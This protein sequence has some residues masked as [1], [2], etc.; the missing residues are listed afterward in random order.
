MLTDLVIQSGYVRAQFHEKTGLWAVT[1]MRSSFD[2]ITN[3][4][5]GRM[6][7]CKWL[8][9]IVFLE[10]VAGVPGMVGGMVGPLFKKVPSCLECLTPVANSGK[11]GGI[12]G[13]SHFRTSRTPELIGRRVMKEAR[14]CGVLGALPVQHLCRDALMKC[15]LLVH[16]SSDCAPWRFSIC[17]FILPQ[18]ACHGSVK[19]WALWVLI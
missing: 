10:T 2:F 9:R 16:R 14:T 11:V 18:V 19:A 8:Q 13:P 7:E 15:R 1:A 17:L 4:G 12:V 3:Y 6:N 5:P